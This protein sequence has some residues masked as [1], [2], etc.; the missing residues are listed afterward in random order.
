MIKTG[1]S[2]LNRDTASRLEVGG[3]LDIHEKHEKNSTSIKR[4]IRDGRREV[5]GPSAETPQHVIH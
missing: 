5:L 3:K 2:A 1:H 4:K